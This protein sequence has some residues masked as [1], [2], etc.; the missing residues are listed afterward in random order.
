MNAGDDVG[1]AA[2]VQQD[3]TEKQSHHATARSTHQASDPNLLETFRQQADMA[4]R[5]IGSLD[6]E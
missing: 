6:K 2:G 3:A 1:W 4:Q 5:I